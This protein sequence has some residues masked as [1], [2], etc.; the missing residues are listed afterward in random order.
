MEKMEKI[1]KLGNYNNCEMEFHIMK[2]YDKNFW[3]YLKCIYEDDFER[4]LRSDS[5]I[6]IFTDM[7]PH[8]YYNIL[9]KNYGFFDKSVR[10]YYYK[11]VEDAKNTINEI[12]SHLIMNKLVQ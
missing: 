2:T 7:L 8:V 1:I 3:F 12:I 4:T 11:T 6:M 10:C 5:D 9:S